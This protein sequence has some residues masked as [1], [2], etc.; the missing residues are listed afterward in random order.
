ME[1]NRK[2]EVGKVYS[3]R[4]G[5][6]FVAARA[7]KGLGH[8]RYEGLTVRP[9]GTGAKVTFRTEA[10][11]GGG[12][13]EEEWRKKH[14]PQA[15]DLPVPPRGEAAVPARARRAG[16]PAKASAPRKPS[17]LDAA[18]RVLRERGRPMKVDE[19]VKV[20]IEKGYWSTNGKTPAATVYAA[21]IRE[22]ASRKAEARFARAAGEERGLFELSASA[23]AETK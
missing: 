6:A 7:D 21:I 13:T 4:V 17:G 1:T 11:R 9:D 20:A 15:N 19:I 3:V 5:G 18:V 2:V 12:V 8:G 22:I 23:K 10:V 14:T 16:R